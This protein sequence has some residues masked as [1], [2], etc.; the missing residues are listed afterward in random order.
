M[1]ATDPTDPPS[2]SRPDAER[3]A[4]A[5]EEHADARERVDHLE[6][7]GTDDTGTPEEPRRFI[8]EGSEGTEYEDNAIAP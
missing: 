8:D 1:D 3:T 7:R 5:G 4:A 2:Q 6:D